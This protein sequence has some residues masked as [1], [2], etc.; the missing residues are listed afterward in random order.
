[1]LHLI[2]YLVVFALGF[3]LGR[4]KNFK[5]AEAKFA[6]EVD[7]AKAKAKSL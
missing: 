6:A 2:S 5:S 3:G 4:I 1:M 7:A